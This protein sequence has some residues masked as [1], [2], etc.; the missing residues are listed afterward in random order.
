MN[1]QPYIAVVPAILTGK[2]VVKGMRLAVEFVLGML[3]LLKLRTHAERELGPRF[4]LKEFHDTVLR[5]GAVPLDILENLVNEWIA[6]KRLDK[7]GFAAVFRRLH[8]R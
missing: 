3:K 6:E 2:P 8:S 5:H 4:S 7:P 1:W